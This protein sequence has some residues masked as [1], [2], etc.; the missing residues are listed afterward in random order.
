[1]TFLFLPGSDL[2]TRIYPAQRSTTAWCFR[3]QTWMS[4]DSLP[5]PARL[6]TFMISTV[7]SATMVVSLTEFMISAIL[8]VAMVVSLRVFMM[9]AVLSVAM[10]V[11]LTEFVISTVLFAIMVGLTKFMI[12]GILSV[13]MV[14]S[15][16]PVLN[17]ANVCSPEHTSDTSTNYDSF[18]N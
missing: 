5:D 17:W 15:L 16:K 18:L 8:S 4:R 13:A 3:I 2:C 7:L 9:S 10:V 12:S 11:S 6:S 1:M 14:V